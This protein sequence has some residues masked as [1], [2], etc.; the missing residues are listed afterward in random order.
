MVTAAA[1][2]IEPIVAAQS[3]AT[4]ARGPAPH[5]AAGASVN[6]RPILARFAA[7]LAVAPD[8]AG[9]LVALYAEQYPRLAVAFVIR[10]VSARADAAVQIETAARRREVAGLRDLAFLLYD[11]LDCV[12]PSLDEPPPPILLD[13]DFLDGLARLSPG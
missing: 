4:V 1:G 10:A 6:D 5:F 7:D 9:E 11:A 3:P 13:L 12:L 2:E 8:I